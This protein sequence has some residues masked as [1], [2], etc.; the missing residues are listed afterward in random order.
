[1]RKAGFKGDPLAKNDRSGWQRKP[2]I[3]R[4]VPNLAAAA[5]IYMAEWLTAHIPTKQTLNK[6]KE[7]VFATAEFMA[8]YAYYDKDKGR[9]ILG[10]G[11]IPSQE[12]HKAEN[13]FNPP[14]ELT[15]WNWAL[16][17][18]QQWKER[19]KQPRD[20]QWDDVMSKLSP[21]PQKDGVY[22]EAES[23]P[24]SYTNPKNKPIIHQHW[25]LT[26]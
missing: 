5:F 11:M 12:V 2:I 19:L 9:Y 26:A 17:I 20:K 22:L 24:D 8:S 25:R 6:Y 21:L 3:S 10:K 14:Y 23:A 1:M 4:G 16:G 13:T 18:A 7:L 15:Y